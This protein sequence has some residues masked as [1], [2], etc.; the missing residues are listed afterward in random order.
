MLATHIPKFLRAAAAAAALLVVACQSAP[1]QEMSD[2]RQAISVA[3]EAGA[4]QHAASLIQLA[5]DR[6][7]TAEKYLSERQYA[8]A[9]QDAVSAKKTA[10]EALQ[11]TQASIDAKAP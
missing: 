5:V 9:R 3:Q 7:Q 10:L 11:Q 4:E 8:Q 1:V 6:L 2:A